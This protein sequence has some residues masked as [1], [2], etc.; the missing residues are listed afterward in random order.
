MAIILDVV[1]S[2][3]FVKYA[4]ETGLGPE[5]EIKESKWVG[6]CYLTSNGGYIS[7]FRNVMFEKKMYRL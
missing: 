3:V 4:F 5:V 6:N 7:A 2:L 1:K